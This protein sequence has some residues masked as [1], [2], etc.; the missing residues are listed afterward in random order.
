MPAQVFEA[1]SNLCKVIKDECDKI[2]QERYDYKKEVMKEVNAYKNDIYNEGVEKGRNLLFQL[3]AG[4]ITAEDF[5]KRI[6]KF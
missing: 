2:Q 5:N 1:A 3:N 4:E 6:D